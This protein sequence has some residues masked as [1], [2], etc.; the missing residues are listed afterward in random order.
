[1]LAQGEGLMDAEV[2]TLPLAMACLTEPLGSPSP[3]GRALSTMN[4]QTTAGVDKPSCEDKAGRRAA[5]DAAMVESRAELY[6]FLLRRTRDRE[7]AA[8]LTQE[9][10]SRMMV[11]RDA[12]GIQD[13]VALLY[14]VAYNLVTEYYRSQY[15]HRASQHVSLLDAGVLPKDEPP[16]EAIVD[17]RLAI[18]V[19]VKH[20]LLALPPRCALAFMLNRFDGLSYSQVAQRMGISVKMVEK[21]I[22]RALVACREAVGD[23]DF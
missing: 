23:R 19:L 14:R 10:L 13:R 18:D 5:F 16:V 12:E 22:A 6:A 20:T 4:D 3:R 2:L 7:L 11:Y 8:D 17:A 9:V 15:R 1:M 21:H